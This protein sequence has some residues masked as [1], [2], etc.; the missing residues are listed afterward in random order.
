MDNELPPE[1]VPGQTR[2]EKIMQEKFGSVDFSGLMSTI[3]EKMLGDVDEA[4]KD[5]EKKE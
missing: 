4:K 2:L 1:D 5:A 3:V